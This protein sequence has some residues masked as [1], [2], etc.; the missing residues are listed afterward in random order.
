MKGKFS[1]AV[2]VCLFFA[3]AANAQD[4]LKVNEAETKA[5]STR[6]G[7]QINLAVESRLPKERRAKV[8][9]EILD[10]SDAQLARNDSMETVTGGKT[11]LQIPFRVAESD[12]KTLMWQRLRYAIALDGKLVSGI[13]SL[14]EIMPELFGLRVESSENISAGT[15]YEVRV[16]AVHPTKN[17]AVSDV[18]ID[19]EIEIEIETARQNR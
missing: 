19:A 10:K 13:V 4:F 16:R 6:T 5:F 14:S 1:L 12:A 15:I 17:S 3:I 18:E 8:S 7:L 11:V 2:L 9:L